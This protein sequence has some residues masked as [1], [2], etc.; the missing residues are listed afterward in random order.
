[1]LRLSP[2]ARAEFRAADKNK[3]G[4][5]S[6]AEFDAYLAGGKSSWS[7]VRGVEVGEETL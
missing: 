2:K 3:D 5:L 7:Q 4:V 6:K 1:M